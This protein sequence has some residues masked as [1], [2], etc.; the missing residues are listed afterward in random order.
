MHQPGQPYPRVRRQPSLTRAALVYL[1]GLT[2]RDGK[3]EFGPDLTGSVGV[4]SAHDDQRLCHQLEPGGIP[5][6]RNSGCGQRQRAPQFGLCQLPQV[7]F[8]ALAV[9]IISV[10][11]KY[12]MS[13]RAGPGISGVWR[14]WA[15]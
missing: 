7:G 4:D 14:W 11:P 13:R 10:L 5:P 1:A 6:A 9:H 8:R 15:I 12:G 2:D 3:L